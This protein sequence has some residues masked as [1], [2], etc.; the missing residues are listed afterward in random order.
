MRLKDWIKSQRIQPSF[1]IGKRIRVI[2]IS[3]QA[4]KPIETIC[5]G[6]VES[7]DDNVIYFEGGKLVWNGEWFNNCLKIQFVEDD[8]LSLTE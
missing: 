6:V 5:E 4:S 3:V 2:G 8:F 7:V 1:M